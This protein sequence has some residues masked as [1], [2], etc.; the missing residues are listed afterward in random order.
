MAYLRSQRERLA[1]SEQA[2]RQDMP[3]A[4]FDLRTAVRRIRAALRTYRPLVVDDQLVTELIDELCWRLGR[5]V[6]VVRDAQVARARLTVGLDELD[7]ELL[8]GPVRALVSEHFAQV[9]AAAN[10]ALSEALDSPPWLAARSRLELFIDDPELTVLAERPAETELLVHIRST[11]QLLLE[12]VRTSDTTDDGLHAVRKTAR[13]L[14]E[15]ALMARP[16]VG[17]PVKRF[18]HRLQKL[19]RMLGEHQDTVISRRVLAELLATAERAGHN[20]F[21]FALLYGQERARAEEVR[22]NLPRRWDRTWR[23]AYLGWLDGPGHRPLEALHPQMTAS[24]PAD[25]LPAN[26]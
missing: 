15:S 11:A 25:R 23:P 13:H 6:S 9:D 2:V 1:Q 21:T 24:V 12:A 19:L 16:V 4:A 5:A 7:D 18:D 14:R 17:S 10:A 3:D 20:G 26:P 8:R 22:N